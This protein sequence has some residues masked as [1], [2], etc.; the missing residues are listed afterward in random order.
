MSTDRHSS[1]PIPHTFHVQY[2]LQS[3]HYS[4]SLNRHPPTPPI[5][6]HKHFLRKGFQTSANTF[7]RKK[8]TFGIAHSRWVGRVRQFHD[9]DYSLW[10]E[11]WLT[12]QNPSGYFT[13]R[14]VL[15][16]RNSKFCPHCIYVFCIY[17]RTNSDYFS[18]QH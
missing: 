16:F 17:L 5:F 6:L 1:H 7:F 3:R 18:I 9:K 12:L 4:P 10:E 14:Q 13:Y 2:Y 15:A 8:C 11:M